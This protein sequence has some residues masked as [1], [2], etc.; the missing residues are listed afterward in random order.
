MSSCSLFQVDAARRAVGLRRGEGGDR[1]AQFPSSLHSLARDAEAIPASHPL[2]SSSTESEWGRHDSPLVGV[3]PRRIFRRLR[4]CVITSQMSQ[5]FRAIPPRAS[6]PRHAAEISEK[7]LRPIRFFALCAR[8][9]AHSRRAPSHGRRPARSRSAHRSPRDSHGDETRFAP[10]LGRTSSSSAVTA[11]PP[12]VV[13]AGA[14]VFGASP[15]ADARAPNPRVC[16]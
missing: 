12:P 16:A 2:F 6:V 5:I 7:V 13:Q 9:G 3:I 14:S 11:N 8:R 15:P 4:I 10:A 1:G